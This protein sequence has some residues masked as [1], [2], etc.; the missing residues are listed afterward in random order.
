MD[1]AYKILAKAKKEGE[2]FSDTIRRVVGKKKDVS[3]F[4]NIW[5]D[6]YADSVK[7]N[8]GDMRTRSRKRTD[9]IQQ[10]EQKG[11]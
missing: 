6:K 5:S 4:S 3:E 8:I 10:Q 7:T 2:S 9:I 1:N 11:I